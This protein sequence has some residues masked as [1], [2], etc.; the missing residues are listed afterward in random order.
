MGGDSLVT[1]ARLATVH[2]IKHTTVAT[3]KHSQTLPWSTHEQRIESIISTL[4]HQVLHR[5]RLRVRHASPPQWMVT[6]PAG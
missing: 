4:N 6:A 3:R 1:A 5:S 2:A